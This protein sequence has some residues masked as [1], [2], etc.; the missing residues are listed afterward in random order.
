[1]MHAAASRVDLDRFGCLFRGS[2]R[3]SDLLIV[4]GTLTKKM[5]KP[6]ETLYG[7]MLF[8]KYVIAMGSCAISGGIYRESESVIC[9]VDKV[10][11][12]DIVVHGCPPLPENLA[13][14][15]LKLQA[16]ILNPE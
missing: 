15:I 1:M 8:P 13:K 9:G 7:Q 11:P 14:A 6:L 3:Q 4:A 16:K 2:P 10:I 5:A 12:V